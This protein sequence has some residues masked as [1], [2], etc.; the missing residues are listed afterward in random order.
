MKRWLVGIL[1]AAL[2]GVLVVNF[3]AATQDIATD[4]LAIDVLAPKERGLGN[5]LQVGGYRLGMIIGGGVIGTS[6]AYH[7]AKLGRPDVVLLE[8]KELTSGTT[9]HA[10]G[11]VGQLRA[12]KNMTKLAQYTSELYAGLEVETGQ[13]LYEWDP[14]SNVILTDRPGK[15]KFID[16]IEGVTMREEFDE[17]LDHLQLAARFPRRVE[18]IGAADVGV[19]ANAGSVPLRFKPVKQVDLP[20]VFG[21]YRVRQQ[22]GDGSMGDVWLAY[23]E[24]LRREVALKVPKPQTDDESG[25]LVE[26]FYREARAVAKLDHPKIC[27]VF[28]VGEIDGIHFSTMVFIE[29]NS[30]SEYISAETLQ[31]ERHVVTVVHKLA[32]VSYTHL[33]LPT[34]LLV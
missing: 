11:L 17:R 16:I 25:E 21:R 14:Y 2:A 8:R 6:L 27:K 23:D 29:G 22:I 18:E 30:L 28:D 9:W 15:I 5:S 32:P 3:L 26:R 1:L 10:A 7:L 4:A 31:P 24:E 13:A 20:E 12:T 19:G 33:T 34:I